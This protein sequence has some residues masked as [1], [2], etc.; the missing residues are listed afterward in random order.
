MPLAYANNLL[1]VKLSNL[2]YG[3]VQIVPRQTSSAFV[4]YKGWLIL[5]IDS[6]YQHQI[7]A[8]NTVPDILELGSVQSLQSTRDAMDRNQVAF[9]YVRIVHFI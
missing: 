4:R 8:I 1:S 6:I 7:S 5:A 2:K 9:M 3:T